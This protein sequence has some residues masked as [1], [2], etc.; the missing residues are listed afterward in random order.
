[1]YFI[2]DIE[3]AA[4]GLAESY[5]AKKEY[6]PD[7]AL[8]GLDEPPTKITELKNDELRITRLAEW[9]ESQAAKIQGSIDAK[10]RADQDK[11]ALHWW[12]GKVICICTRNERGDEHTFQ[13]E[14]ECVIISDFFRYLKSREH[15]AIGKSSNDFDRPFLIGRA[16]HH[17]IGI[18]AQWRP[19]YPIDDVNQIFSNRTSSS[20]ISSLANYAWGLCLE[21]K[22]GLGS[23]VADWYKAGNH[24]QIAEYCRHDV[25]LTAEI[26]RRYEV[27]FV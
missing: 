17:D 26:F 8:N 23:D 22:K 7:S 20:Q 16:L 24:Q 2:Y 14:S 4:N 9:R 1:M 11:A 15:R 19:N 18:P 27:D 13:D 25:A 3:T 10:R 5:F 12:T 21:E 6:A